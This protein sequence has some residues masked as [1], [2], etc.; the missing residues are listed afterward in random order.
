MSRPLAFITVRDTKSG[1]RWEEPLDNLSI[2][3][4]AIT[5]EYVAQYAQS[6]VTFFNQIAP[7]NQPKRELIS[8]RIAVR[9]ER[10]KA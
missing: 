4:P 7:A 5:A 9:T 10:K 1:E 2:K 6:V 8:S 3:D